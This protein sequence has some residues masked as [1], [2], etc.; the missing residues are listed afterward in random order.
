M[1]AEKTPLQTVVSVICDALCELPLEDRTRAITA[2][3]I[4]LGVD[5]M[6]QQPPRRERRLDD[7]PL[8]PPPP[9]PRVASPRGGIFRGS[10]Q[11]VE[12]RPLTDRS[13]A[14]PPQETTFRLPPPWSATRRL[15]P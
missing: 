14:R 2:A 7:E 1:G 10:G 9:L 11:I 3:A 12:V 5:A 13:A 6:T 8:L 4:A 15:G